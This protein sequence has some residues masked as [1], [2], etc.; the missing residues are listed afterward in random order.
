MA[1]VYADDWQL[2]EPASGQSPR[3]WAKSFTQQFTAADG[4]KLYLGVLPGG[5]TFDTVALVTDALGAG[6]TLSI[7][8]EPMKSG[9]GIAANNSQWFSAA[10]VAA[11]GRAVSV[12]HPVG[13]NKDVKLVATLAGGALDGTKKISVVLSGEGNGIE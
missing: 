1:N 9:D 13:W 10:D 7:G 2:V 5:V 6:V 11:K 8:I 4:D 12:E 3:G